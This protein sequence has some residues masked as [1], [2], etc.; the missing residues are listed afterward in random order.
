MEDH[1]ESFTLPVVANDVAPWVAYSDAAC[2]HQLAP[3]DMNEVDWRIGKPMLTWRALQDAP[4]A[5]AY[6]DINDGEYG[7]KRVNYAANWARMKVNRGWDWRVPVMFRASRLRE[8]EDVEAEVEEFENLSEEAVDLALDTE[9]CMSS[10]DSAASKTLIM[11]DEGYY[12]DESLPVS[13]T[14]S[15]SDKDFDTP[16]STTRVGLSMAASFV[17]TGRRRPRKDSQDVLKD[18]GMSYRRDVDSDEILVGACEDK[19]IVVVGDASTPHISKASHALEDI[20]RHPGISTHLSYAAV[21]G[22]SYAYWV[23]WKTVT[24]VTAGVILGGAMHMSQ[25]C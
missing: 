8:V 22:L 23:D 21:K 2:E 15:T 25:R 16:I 1:E 5:P 3:R 19:S 24:I 14:L 20:S 4:D 7:E 9:A 12:S 11:L 18:I 10:C 6:L 13:P 17:R